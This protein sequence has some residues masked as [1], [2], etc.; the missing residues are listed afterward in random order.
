MTRKPGASVL[1]IALV[2]LAFTAGG[3]QAS[4]VTAT[5]SS[6]GGGE[7]LKFQAAAGE[8][9]DVS[10]SVKGAFFATGW[11]VTDNTSTL[12]AG[13]GCQSLDAHTASCPFTSTEL[14]IGVQVD[15]GDGRDWADVAQA[16]GRNDM[17]FPCYRAAVDGGSGT[18]VIW[19]ADGTRSLL[20][21][22]EGNDVLRAGAAGAVLNGGADSDYM[23]GSAANDDLIA[24]SGNDI[25][26]WGYGGNDRIW[27]GN[28]ADILDGGTGNDTI[29]GGRGPDDMLGRSGRDTFQAKDGVR[30]HV[31]GGG[32]TDSARID[33]GK[34]TTKSV[35]RV[36]G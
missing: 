4:T 32:Q 29:N 8:E 15:L 2:A 13:A 35:E 22:E 14:G 31:N 3:A 28:G 9:N 16:C 11:L 23:V 10:I 25:H 19:G 33:R 34:D 6:D 18:D 17:D 26:A 20:R 30:D 21:G 7:D 24:G 12:T 36:R 27:G 1:L 5:P